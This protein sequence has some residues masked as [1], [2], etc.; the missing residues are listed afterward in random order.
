M[1]SPSC[2]LFQ[3]ASGASSTLGDIPVA[4]TAA[5][6]ASP[7]LATGLLHQAV[8]GTSSAQVLVVS[9]FQAVSLPAKSVFKPTRA[10]AFVSTRFSRKRFCN[11][12]CLFTSEGFCRGEVLWRTRLEIFSLH[13]MA[14]PHVQ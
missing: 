13:K 6:P 11:D 8:A 14:A 7:T 3:T 9:P 5:V 1:T 4:A 2:S 10:V 12:E